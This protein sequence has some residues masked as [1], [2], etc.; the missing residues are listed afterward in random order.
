MGNISGAILEADAKETNVDEITKEN[1][2]PIWT[3]KQEFEKLVADNMD[4]KFTQIRTIVF[5]KDRRNPNHVIGWL[6]KGKIVFPH[7]NADIKNLKPGIPY[8]CLIYEKDRYAY[9]K[10]LGEQYEPRVIVTD[11]GVVILIIRI[12]DKTQQIICKGKNDAEKLAFA[13]KKI[14][15]LGEPSFKV[16]IRKN[17]PRVEK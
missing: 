6:P 12:G 2:H 8:I 5:V 10:V 3:S 14:A 4:E 9:A 13:Y 1:K 16:I 11:T 7:K 17:R 15:E